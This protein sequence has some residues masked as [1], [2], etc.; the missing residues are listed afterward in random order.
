MTSVTHAC[1]PLPAG[2]V[3]LVDG[4]AVQKE[5]LPL[6][7]LGRHGLPPAR[8]DGGHDSVGQRP[9]RHLDR[10]FAVGGHG[11][12]VGAVRGDGDDPEPDLGFGEAGPAV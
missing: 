2:D 8:R 12:A 1:D 11:R 9:A 4:V 3:S 6:E 10:L 5:R 7:G